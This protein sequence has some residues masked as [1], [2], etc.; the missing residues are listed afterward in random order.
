MNS[1]GAFYF[2]A[3]LFTPGPWQKSAALKSLVTKNAGVKEF[4]HL[5]SENRISWIFGLFFENVHE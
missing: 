4:L 2:I 3:I 1:E 5:C